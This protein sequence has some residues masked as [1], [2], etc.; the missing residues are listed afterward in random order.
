[1]PA[2]PRLPLL[3]DLLDAHYRP[4]GHRVGIVV[5]S[6]CPESDAATIAAVLAA[7][8]HTAERRLARLRPRPDEPAARAEDVAGF[9]ARYGHEYGVAWLPG[10][11]AAPAERVAIGRAAREAGC[12]IGWDL[13]ATT[14]DDPLV[15]LDGAPVDFALWRAP[16]DPADR[17]RAHRPG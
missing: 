5:A 13:T 10:H 3:R 14:T 9:L 4:R 2:Q 1:M 12:A 7:H 15:L 8:G 17:A 11:V 16:G 6:D